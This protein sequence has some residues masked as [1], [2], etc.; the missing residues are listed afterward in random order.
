MENQNNLLTPTEEQEKDIVR[1]LLN[2]AIDECGF[3]PLVCFGLC[4]IMGTSI[5]GLIGYKVFIDTRK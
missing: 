4:V 5:G 3:M 2:V 1:E